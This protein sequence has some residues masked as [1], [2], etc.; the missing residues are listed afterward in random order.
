[1]DHQQWDGQ[2]TEGPLLLTDAPY[3]PTLF[4]HKGV[5]EFLF[6]C[7]GRQHRTR[8]EA[9]FQSSPGSVE[10]KLVYALFNA[11]EAYPERHAV[12]VM[13]G[14]GW[15]KGVRSWL[16]AAAERYAQFSVPRGK[17]IDVMNVPEL[18]AWLNSVLAGNRVVTP[19]CVE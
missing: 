2:P 10:R 8:I 1:M 13:G 12:I 5:T 11:I 18:K 4:G 14:D 19:T 15:S 6:L 17:R 7:P 3:G 16:R 9:K